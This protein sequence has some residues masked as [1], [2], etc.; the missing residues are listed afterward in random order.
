MWHLIILVY[1]HIH[2][3]LI[4]CIF[5]H[6]IIMTFKSSIS[7]PLEIIWSWLQN[8]RILFKNNSFQPFQFCLRSQFSALKAVGSPPQYRL[9]NVGLWAI[10]Q[11]TDTECSLFHLQPYIQVRGAQENQISQDGENSLCQINPGQGRTREWWVC[12]CQN[13]WNKILKMV[14]EVTSRSK[15]RLGAPKRVTIS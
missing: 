7:W 6:F 5:Y 8:T 13:Q 11:S 14:K 2:S 10:D 1:H 12:D 15:S 4:H 3:Y 9:D